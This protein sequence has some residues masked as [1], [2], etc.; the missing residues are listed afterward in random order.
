LFEAN[1][2]A[3]LII[4][5]LFMVYPEYFS[6]GATESADK[7][8]DGYWREKEVTATGCTCYLSQPFY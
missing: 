7:Q 6:A 3:W 4:I 5:S 8:N 1:N 2:S